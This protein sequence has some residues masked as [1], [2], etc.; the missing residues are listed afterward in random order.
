MQIYDC[1]SDELECL[2]RLLL[3]ISGMNML[4]TM[5]ILLKFELSD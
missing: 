5:T 1:R 3:S 2:T 4:I